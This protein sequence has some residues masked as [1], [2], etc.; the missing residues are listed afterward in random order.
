MS[1]KDTISIKKR[2]AKEASLH[3]NDSGRDRQ[4]PFLECATLPMNLIIALI[5]PFVQDRSTWN[6]LCVANKELRDAGRR[7]IPPWPETITF[8]P[9]G[10]NLWRATAFSPGGRYL[11]CVT[12]PVEDMPGRSGIPSLVHILDRRNGLQ[13]SLNGGHNQSAHCLSFSGDGKFLAA[14]GT[15]GL[16]HIWPTNRSRISAHQRHKS[17]QGHGHMAVQCLAFASDSNIL[18]FASKGEITL[19]NVEDGV[20]IHRFH[21]Q[22]GNAGSLV[23]SGVG[24]S[25]QCLVATTDG[26]LIRISRNSSHDSEFTSDVV[27]DRATGFYCTTFSPCG[28]F[29]ATADAT[30]KLCLYKIETNGMSTMTQSVTLPGYCSLRTNAGMT[31]SSDHKML[32]VISDTS[33]DD[34]NTIVR[35][36]DAKD[37]TL[38]R[39]FKWQQLRGKL[40]GSLAIDPSSRYLAT[41]SQK[42]GIRL[43]TI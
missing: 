41:A 2:S 39:Q 18:A 25:I 38:Q 20:C 33:L 29:L 11:A 14:G 8:P 5:L 4:Q 35:L 17:L 36:L 43:C 23:F 13:T 31:F 26:S 27:F 9:L 40:R 24:E 3:A 7:M 34:E 21:H 10:Q 1:S 30:N 19:W 42:G 12:R 28:S 22:Y 37:L 6:N 16:I 15:N 32:V